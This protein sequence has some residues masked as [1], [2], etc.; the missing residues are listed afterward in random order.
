MLYLENFSFPGSEEDR[1]LHPRDLTPEEISRGVFA[2]KS[3]RYFKGSVYPFQVLP[4]GDFS[5][6]EFEPITIFYGRNG[7]GKTT[8]LNI[9]AEKIGLKRETLYNKGE[10]FDEYLDF[11]EYNSDPLTDKHQRIRMP[12]PESSCII[13]SDDVFRYNLHQREINE[14]RLQKKSL[15]EPDY[16]FKMLEPVE[17]NI[18]DNYE[19]F[20]EQMMSR[21]E[22][23]RSY[24]P[25]EARELS[26]GESGFRYFVEKINTPA[27]YLLDESENSLSVEKQR[28][29]ADYIHSSA[30]F[31]ECQFIIATHS[32]IF[33]AMENAQIYDL[34]TEPVKV[35]PWTE[36][37][38][39]RQWFDF[40][41]S[42]RTE[43]DDNSRK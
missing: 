11:C 16:H 15:I 14:R 42:H 3:M 18:L 19:L 29:L 2:D 22:Y 23:M 36:L 34:D 8:A 17:G 9:I 5:Y 10:L 30:R 40:F 43:F 24:L 32:P 7:S 12:V 27:L 37:N 1:F 33:L 21:S 38:G 39:V 26:N 6:L 31:F 4:R 20:K 41:M 13:V 28:E 25:E 35:K